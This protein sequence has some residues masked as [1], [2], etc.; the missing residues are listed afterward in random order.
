M[1]LEPID[2]Q[3]VDESGDD[4]DSVGGFGI[5]AETVIEADPP[6]WWSHSRWGPHLLIGTLMV[7][8]TLGVIFEERVRSWIVQLF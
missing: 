2:S 8:T 1:P 6:P 3:P 7:L 5:G 4:S